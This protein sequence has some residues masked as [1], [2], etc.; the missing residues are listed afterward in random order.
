MSE[1]KT[2]PCGRPTV[3]PYHD[4]CAVC[5]RHAKPRPRKPDLNFGLR[6]WDSLVLGGLTLGHFDKFR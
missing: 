4:H 5:I 2:C 1:P 3:T 6:G